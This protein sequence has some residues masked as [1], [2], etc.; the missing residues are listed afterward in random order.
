MGQKNQNGTK[1]EPK[2]DRN[3]TKIG[4]EMEPKW[5]QNGTKMAPKSK[6]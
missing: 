5:N 4:T 1:M 3:E 6:L 2:W